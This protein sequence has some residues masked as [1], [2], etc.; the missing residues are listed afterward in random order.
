MTNA[1]LD[2]LRVSFNTATSPATPTWTLVDS[3]ITSTTSLDPILFTDSVTGRTF[4]SQLVGTTSLAAF[5]DDDGA[6][7]TVSQGGGIASGVD[8]QTVG[9]G[10]FKEC[11]PLQA[12][13]NPGPV[14]CCSRAVRSQAIRTQSTMRRRISPM[15]RWR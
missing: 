2:T 9:G 5:T 7:Y 3:P 11:T 1:V 12:Q 13:L 8:H 6:T 4:V 14:Q 15:L 10:P